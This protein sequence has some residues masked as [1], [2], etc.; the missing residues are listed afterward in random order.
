M[1]VEGYFYPAGNNISLGEHPVVQSPQ[2]LITQGGTG[3]TCYSGSTSANG[4]STHST[5]SYYVAPLLIV[6]PLNASKIGIIEAVNTSAAGTGS[7]TVRE[8]FGLYAR[9]SDSLTLVSSWM[10]GFNVSQNSATAQTLSVVT[11]SA[12]NSILSWGGNSTA[13]F[14]GTKLVPIAQGATSWVSAAQYFG[15]FGMHVISAGI[16]PVSVSVLTPN[17]TMIELGR[18]PAA[19]S[20]WNAYGGAFSS[21]SMTNVANSNQWL[22]PPFIATVNI[23]A[24]RSN[25]QI[26]P[27]VV[28]RGA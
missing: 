28:I 5:M 26:I 18:D 3:L 12:S 11:G 25:E 21:T 2:P 9:S 24:T 14:T 10:G 8:Y 1:P 22:M 13:S 19:T 20:I 17:M 23:T 4:A 16:Q 27:T 7:A 6:A 15:V